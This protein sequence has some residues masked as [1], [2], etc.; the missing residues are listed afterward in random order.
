VRIRSIFTVGAIIAAACSS[1]QKTSAVADSG[2]ASASA[3]AKTDTA[4]A[5]PAADTARGWTVALGAVGPIRVGMNAEDLKRVAGDFPAPKPGAECAYVH[6][7]LAPTGVLVMLARGQVV[8]IDIDSAGTRTD[9]GVGV[10]D[11]SSRVTDAYAGRVTATPH[12]YVPGGQY[13]TARSTS[14]ADSALR[15]VFEIA[16]GRVTR[17]RTGR[18]PEVEWVERC[19]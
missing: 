4:P 14:P 2:G 8:R 15:I 5:T 13:L 16:E 1:E 7:S 6:P 18:T 9:A 10:G 11:S 17:F 12:K 3:Q 19:G